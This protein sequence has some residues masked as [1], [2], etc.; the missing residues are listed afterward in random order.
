MQLLCLQA[1]IS[2]LFFSFGRE[3]KWVSQAGWGDIELVH[4]LSY[5]KQ[6]CYWVLWGWEIIVCLT[7]LVTLL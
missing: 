3:G 7:S 5:Y 2:S 1:E 4:F 6:N